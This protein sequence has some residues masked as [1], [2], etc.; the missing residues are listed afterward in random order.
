[1]VVVSRDGVSLDEFSAH[2]RKTDMRFLVG[3][4]PRLPVLDQ[5]FCALRFQRSAQKLARA[6][7]WCS[8]LA[9]RDRMRTLLGSVERLLSR[10]RRHVCFSL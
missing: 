4:A 2:R 1:M 7:S 10:T 9:I 5:A 3:T 8:G 6:E